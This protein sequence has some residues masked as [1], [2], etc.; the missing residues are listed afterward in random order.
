VKVFRNS[1]SL[2][3]HNEAPA[4]EVNYVA[5]VSARKRKIRKG[6]GSA[7]SPDVIPLHPDTVD[8]SSKLATKRSAE[9][10]CEPGLPFLFFS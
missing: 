6:E 8:A 4:I 3:K 7:D 10:S 1:F 2:E 5:E 9:A